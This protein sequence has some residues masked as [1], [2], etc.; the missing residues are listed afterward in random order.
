MTAND[1]KFKGKDKFED[2]LLAYAILC[3]FGISKPHITPYGFA[4]NW[5]NNICKTL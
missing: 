3:G 5:D 4:I 2:K 1:V